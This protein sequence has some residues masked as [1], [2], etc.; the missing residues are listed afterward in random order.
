MSRTEQNRTV[1][2]AVEQ[3]GYNDIEKDA[4]ML[5]LI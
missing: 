5:M 4:E 1:F 3:Q 2:I